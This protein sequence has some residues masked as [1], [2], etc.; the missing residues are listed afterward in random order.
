MR[1][2]I[3]PYLWM[4]NSAGTSGLQVLVSVPMLRFGPHQLIAS[5]AEVTSAGR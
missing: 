2:A 4:D 5:A 1:V 3:R